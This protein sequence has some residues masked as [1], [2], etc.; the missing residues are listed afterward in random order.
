MRILPAHIDVGRVVP[1]LSRILESVDRAH[2]KSL[3]LDY[4]VGIAAGRQHGAIHKGQR[5]VGTPRTDWPRSR[6]RI[7]DEVRSLQVK[8]ARSEITDCERGVRA[9]AL[10]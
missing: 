8:S 4:R 7:I 9:E 3:A 10:F 6:R 2:G 5:L 1:A